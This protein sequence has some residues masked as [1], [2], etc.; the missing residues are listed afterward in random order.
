MENFYSGK[1]VFITGGAG[2]IGSH[3]L[4]ALL[5]RG[6]IITI[7]DNLSS[8]LVKNVT[9][10]FDKHRIVYRK[11]K[12]NLYAKK[13]HSFLFCDFKDY[14][15][16]YKAIKDNSIVFHLAAE[17]GGRGYIDTHPAN[18]CE[19]F[20]INTNVIKA[21]YFV[22]ADRVVFASTACVYPSELQKSY[23]SSYLLKE[24][25]AFKN[26]W[27]NA[28]R[29]YGWAKLMGEMTLSAFFKQYGLKHSI[30]RYVTAY[31]PRENDTHAII[32]LIKRAVEKKDPY[33]VWGSGEQDRDFTYVDDIVEGTLLACEKITDGTPINLGTTRRY[34]IKD[35][36]K[37]ILQ[38]IG[39][40]PK[41]IFDKTKPEGVATRALAI[42]RA[43]KILGWEPKISLKEGITKTVGWYV[44]ARPK[45]VEEII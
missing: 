25:D 1:R 26:E 7:G 22:G 41:I 13:G 18:C 6:A 35:V 33:V 40:S 3:L 36:A 9:D 21:S 31:G 34:K 39:Y 27:A 20:T 17:F 30:V 43:K 14:S 10:I 32:A 24:E 44:K 12:K 5:E 19:N 38:E 15:E 42:S 23:D 37:M 16:T 8:G 11:Y 29:E 4:D 2:F 28:D 45:S